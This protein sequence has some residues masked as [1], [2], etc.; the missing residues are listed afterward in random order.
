MSYSR[1]NHN[2]REH[3]SVYSLF[4]R[5]KVNTAVWLKVQIFWGVNSVST[6]SYWYFER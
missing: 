1:H 2:I 4:E 5:N 3:V 6:G